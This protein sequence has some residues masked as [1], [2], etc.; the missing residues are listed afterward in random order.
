[1]KSLKYAIENALATKIV[2]M[3]QPGNVGDLA[4]KL[5]MVLPVSLIDLINRL[6]ALPAREKGPA[7]ARHAG[8][9]SVA[10]FNERLANAVLAAYAARIP[11][12]PFELPDVVVDGKTVRIAGSVQLVPP[13]VAF[14]ERLD[15]R[16]TASLGVQGLLS[17][18]SPLLATETIEVTLSTTVDVPVA[19]I[20][21]DNRV[22]VT[23]DLSRIVIHRVAATFKSSPPAATFQSAIAGPDVLALVTRILR[24]LSPLVSPPLMAATISQPISRGVSPGA[25]PR[26][27]IRNRSTFPPYPTRFVLSVTLGRIALR[28]FEGAMTVAADFVGITTGDSFQLV[29]LLGEFSP[30][31]SY[32]TMVDNDG[33]LKEGG[34]EAGVPKEAN[35]VLLVNQEVISNILATQVSPGF[36]RGPCVDTQV[37]IH[38]VSVRMGYFDAGPPFGPGYGL[39][40]QLDASAYGTTSEDADGYFWPSSALHTP[41]TVTIYAKLYSNDPRTYSHPH[42]R[43]NWGFRIVNSSLDLPSW[44][45]FALLM[46]SL[47]LTVLIP[48]SIFLYVAIAAIGDTF[49]EGLLANLVSDAEA[50]ILNAGQAAFGMADIP[51]FQS[52]SFAGATWDVEIGNMGFSEEGAEAQISIAAQGTFGIPLSQSIMP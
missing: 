44:L 7:R 23:L 48:L 15:S 35:L 3:F 16:V 49:L 29:N 20:V 42:L 17:L 27:S 1:V 8:F 38:D 5:G 45:P 40:M 43:P 50:K 10:S 51:M 37:L 4:G 14:H 41:A 11:P 28:P 47:L 36:D 34:T 2:P 32:F 30:L 19:A 13:T 18:S 39:R 26:G 21:N 31:I 6:D 24:K 33:R 52:V 46:P 9:A 25:N 12:Q 22:C